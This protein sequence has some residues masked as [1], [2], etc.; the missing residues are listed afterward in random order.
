MSDP[1]VPVGHCPA[2]RAPVF[3]GE[4]YCELCGAALGSEPTVE[5]QDAAPPV[6]DQGG[7]RSSVDKGVAAAISDRGWHRPRNEDAVALAAVGRR[8]AVA[9]CD[10]VASTVQAHRAAQAASAAAI[11]VLGEALDLADWPPADQRQ[12]LFTRA[13]H[14]A[15]R[16][17][18][19]VTDSQ[20]LDDGRA[21]SSTTLVAAL[22]GPGHLTVGNVGDS[23]AYWLDRPGG[24]HRRL[25]VDDS[26]AE[27]QIAEGVAPA[28][29]YADPDARAITRWIGADAESI[30][31]RITDLEVTE[32]G[33]L[34]VCTDGL[35]NYFELPDQLAAVVADRVGD[36]PATIAQ[37]LTDAALDAGGRDNV[38][39]AV[40]PV[41]PVDRP[42]SR[43]E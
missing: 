8:V 36:R 19:A 9:V 3:D 24:A 42:P 1:E 16:A 14:E 37:S 10:G 25:T 31:P 43:K 27:M 2:C 32:P 28:E 20:G 21:P 38:T 12:D 11:A 17:V 4:N 40:I 30:E 41:G 39:V 22:A 7:Q 23:R 29:A 5:A 26:S 33:L 15:Q 13:F 18:V 6:V 35:S 34:V